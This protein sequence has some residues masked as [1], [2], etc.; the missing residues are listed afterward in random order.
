MRRGRIA[1]AIATILFFVLAG[2]G[3]A[4]AWWSTQA[5][6]RSTV[7]AGVVGSAPACSAMTTLVNG[8]FESPAI[9]AG[10]WARSVV[11]GWT[12]GDPAGVELWNN[13][14]G[15]AAS[16]GA[17][18]AEIN[19]N[20]ADTL[21]QVFTTTPGQTL[22]WSLMHRGR[23]GVDTMTVALGPTSGAGVV[24]ATFSDGNAA[25]GLHSGTYVVPAGQTT[26]KISLVATGSAGGDLSYGNFVDDVKVN[27][28]PC[29]ES[30][31]VVT[32]VSRPGQAV[33]VG[34]EI[35]YTTTIVN[36]G[37]SSALNS[38]YTPV[39]PTGATY[40][41]GSLTIDGVAKTDA[42]DGD[43]GAWNSGPTSIA[44][45]I[46]TGATSSAGGTIASA[47]TV[48]VTF[49]AT[50]TSSAASGSLAFSTVTTFADP[51]APTWPITAAP[52]T[53]GTPFTYGPDIVMSQLISP[54][55]MN[56]GTA[57][58]VTWTL[59][60]TNSGLT[61]A[62]AGAV[63]VTLPASSG[64]TLTSS[65]TA[66][67]GTTATRTCSFASLAVNAVLTLTITRT[68]PTTQGVGTLAVSGTAALTGSPIDNFPTNNSATST[69]TIVDATAPTAPGTPV[70]T[71]TTGTA[72]IVTWAASTDNVAVTF[73][74]VYRSDTVLPI[75]TVASP[76]LTY[77]DSTV[78]AW[79][80]YTYSVKARDAAGNVSTASGTSSV[81]TW[82]TGPIDAASNFQVL[83]ESGFTDYCVRATAGTA[84]T[85]VSVS[86]TCTANALR[87]WHITTVGGG[88]VTIN[89]STFA[90]VWDAVTTNVSL[91]TAVAA[92]TSQE[93]TIERIG[94]TAEYVI[95]SHSQP[96]LC[97]NR[98]STTTVNLVA[99]NTGTATQQWTLTER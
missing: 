51:M 43:T 29:L 93:W 6:V 15:F 13:F 34:D 28:G 31:P 27:N 56:Q 19:G 21:A 87:D 70:I 75:G 23:A 92:D 95:R 90:T 48:T 42:A 89:P 30:T 73:Y 26:T 39:I 8:S 91:A 96:T 67:T 68:V 60:A 16:N 78:T 98:N 59:K 63:T 25:W 1:I 77:T 88:Y 53:I 64:Y 7:T 38:S 20:F 81:I 24:Q 62:G 22:S 10:T 33:M 85:A 74:D 84:G 35:K 54:A 66:C 12:T 86:T 52:T 69:L 80:T 45:N 58:A 55:T 57:T 65:G 14:D 97:I 5:T 76:T 47:G 79:N 72:A 2:T 44:A 83:N 32:N 4:S 18:H 71:G 82:P 40:K 50:V 3:V 37:G 41:P 17:Q 36:K 11:T 46:G 94:A 9:P 49:N 99:C 61:A